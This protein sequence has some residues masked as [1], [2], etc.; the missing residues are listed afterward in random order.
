MATGGRERSSSSTAF[1]MVDHTCNSGPTRLVQSNQLH[2]PSNG[3]SKLCLRTQEAGHSAGAAPMGRWKGTGVY[4]SQRA[5]H[6]S[7]SDPYGQVSARQ[8]LQ[9]QGGDAVAGTPGS[10]IS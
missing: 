7:N 5:G 6:S 9:P 10:P 1:V 4:Q 8:Q 3:G 2:I